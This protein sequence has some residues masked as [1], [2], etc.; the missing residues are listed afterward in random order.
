MAFILAIGIG[1]AL[2]A[3]ALKEGFLKTLNANFGPFDEKIFTLF[4]R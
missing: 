1:Y 2:G 3:P 4:Y